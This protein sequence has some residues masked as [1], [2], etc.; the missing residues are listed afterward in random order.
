MHSHLLSTGLLSFLLLLGACVPQMPPTT[1][2]SA[3]IPVNSGEGAPEGSIHN[4]PVPAGVKAARDTLAA[5]LGIASNMITIQTA[6]E[7]Q[8][9]DGCLGLGRPEE[10][11]M[12]VITPG[13][14]VTMTYGGGEYV[15]RTD[16]EGSVVRAE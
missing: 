10:S 16:A 4:L 6:Y 15:Y 3:E 8:W 2:N 11:C 13:Y 12:A 5:R 7:K 9:P 1:E 14:E